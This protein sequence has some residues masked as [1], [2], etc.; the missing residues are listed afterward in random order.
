MSKKPDALSRRYDHADMPNPA[1][2]M[3]AL[4]HFL[5]FHAEMEFDLISVIKEAQGEDESLESLI[6]STKGKESLPPSVRKQFCR[7]NWQEGLLWYKGRIIVPE[8]PEVK[9]RILLQHHA[10]PIAG[11]QGQACTLELV[12]RWYYW[13]GMK[14]QV[15]WFVEECHTCN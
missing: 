7:Y 8:D 1:Q 10:S 12:S 9:R 3:I 5:G 6:A 14:A 4:E 15:N 11:H 2:M 13:P